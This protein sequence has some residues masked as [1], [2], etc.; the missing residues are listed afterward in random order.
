M[1]DNLNY[2]KFDIPALMINDTSFLRN[3]HYH[4][5][6]DDIETINFEKMSEVVNSIL[7]FFIIE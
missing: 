3:P 5:I 2:W 6:T 7:E 4:E 1:S